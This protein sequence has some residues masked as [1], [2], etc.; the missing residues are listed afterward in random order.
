MSSSSVRLCRNG[1]ENVKCCH[2][3]KFIKCKFKVQQRE[4]FNRKNV[5]VKHVKAAGEKPGV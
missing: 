4:K 5:Q 1:K 3:D 2:Q